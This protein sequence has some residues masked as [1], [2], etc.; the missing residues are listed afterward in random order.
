MQK[1]LQK[2]YHFSLERGKFKIL[3]KLFVKKLLL[4]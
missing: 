1:V 2:S 3:E 4:W